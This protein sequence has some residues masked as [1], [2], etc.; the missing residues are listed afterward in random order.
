MNGTAAT[1]YSSITSAYGA[2]HRPSAGGYGSV[3]RAGRSPRSSVTKAV[4]AG[5]PSM[6]FASS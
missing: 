1:G 4:S 3:K 6:R 2:C 5:R